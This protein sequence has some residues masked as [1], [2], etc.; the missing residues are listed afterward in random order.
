MQRHLLRRVLVVIAALLVVAA[1]SSVPRRRSQ[2]APA[3]AAPRANVSL[4]SEARLAN[5]LRRLW[6]CSSDE[7]V[8]VIVA[9]FRRLSDA[10]R[11][12]LVRDGL[13][14]WSAA[15]APRMQRLPVEV[16]RRLASD[17]GDEAGPWYAAHPP[18]DIRV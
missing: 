18:R 16:T 6:H 14:R 2:A 17:W 4:A 1:S 5:E 8:R 11:E 9:L 10:Q 15:G 7:H 3:P 13:L 12:S